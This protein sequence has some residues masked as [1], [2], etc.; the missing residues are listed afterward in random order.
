MTISRFEKLVNESLFVLEYLEAV[1]IRRL[2]LLHSRLT[3]EF[4]TSV[5]W[6]ELIKSRY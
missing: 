1:P 2:R 5:V 3:R 6:C 4:T